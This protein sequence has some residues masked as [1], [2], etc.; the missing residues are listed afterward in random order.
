VARP[1]VTPAMWIISNRPSGNSRSSS[2]R[3]NAFSKDSGIRYS[4]ST[5]HPLGW[6]Q[7][8]SY[9]SEGRNAT[10]KATGASAMLLIIAGELAMVASRTVSFHPNEGVTN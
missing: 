7:T 1:S 3:S 10:T 6:E 8:L 9:F 2:G 5:G 4:I